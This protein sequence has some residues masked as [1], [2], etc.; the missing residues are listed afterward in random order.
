M[1][2]KAG[3][4]KQTRNFRREHSDH[5]DVINIEADRYNDGHLEGKFRVNLGV[6]YPAIADI[7]EA[8]PVTGA[9]KE[10]NCTARTSIGYHRGRDKDYWWKID[11]L[12]SD[13]ETAANLAQMV[14]EY[15]LPW[16]DSLSDLN[17]LKLYMADAGMPFIAAGI[18][19]Y[20][21]D[22]SAAQEYVNR[23]IAEANRYSIH[24]VITWAKKHG[25]RV[26]DDY[27]R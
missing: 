6:Y 16:L 3:F 25:F 20:Q 19:L 15:G 23:S 27:S 14:E 5:T 2:K 10:Y 13:A 11:P 9:P 4:K 21:D 26:P 17:A 1:L 8:L 7:T 22:R 18:A 24:K 12:S